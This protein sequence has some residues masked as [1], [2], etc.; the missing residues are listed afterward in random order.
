MR[1]YLILNILYLISV[2]LYG[3]IDKRIAKRQ[4]KYIHALVIIVFAYLMAIRP[5]ETPDTLNYV[6]GFNNVDSSWLRGASI[7]Q[8]YKSV[9]EYGFIVVMLALRKVTS[10]PRV[11]LFIISLIGMLLTARAFKRLMD[12]VDGTD[13]SG[14]FFDVLSTT[15]VCYGLLYFG[16]SVRAGLAIGLGLT[17]IN[18]MLDKKWVRSGVLFVAAFSIQ[19]TSILYLLIFL[20]LK[21]LPAL[22]KK[23]HYIIWVVSG[24]FLF[25]G[26]GSIVYRSIGPTLI[27][28]M[29]VRDIS[30][31]GYLSDAL[32]TTAAVARTDILTWLI[33]GI[34]I[35]FSIE[36]KPYKKMLNNIMI[37]AL[38]LS[39]F[40]DVMAIS[41]AYD[42]FYMFTVPMYCVL[43][44]HESPI[45][46]DQKH[47]RLLISVLMIM[48]FYIMLELCILKVMQ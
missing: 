24:V 26:L 13:V 46:K 36:E 30:S 10:N 47:K 34:L 45:I 40:N 31:Y 9:F 3:I 37:G 11:F 2:I 33:Y 8:K 12:R 38:I 21:F 27:Q 4:R 39:I 17:F 48:N 22:K 5:I 41:R 16:I 42:L 25:S 14:T 1:Q 20:A 7:L 28:W 15:I 23:T 35:F 44:T 29:N 32:T 18:C 19:R 6:N 43:N